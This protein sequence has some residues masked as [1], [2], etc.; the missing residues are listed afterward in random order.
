M[1]PILNREEIADLLAAVKAGRIAVETPAKGRPARPSLARPTRAIDLVHTFEQGHENGESRLPNFDIVLDTFARNVGI[2]LTNTLQRTFTVAREEI[3]ASTFQQS[4]ENL[5]HQGA[6]GIYTMA[7]LKSGCLFHFD[8]RLAFSL[9]ELMLG[10]ARS[11]DSP[12]LERHLTTIEMSILKT[13]MTMLC[14]ELER[15]MR[16]VVELQI[17]L[18]RVEN[19]F[20]M[21]NIVEPRAEVLVCRFGLRLGGEDAGQMRCIVPYLSFEP[22]REKFRGLVHVGQTAA[23]GWARLFAREVVAMECEVAARSGLIPMTIRRL[24]ALR[25]GE[26]VELPYNPDQP[27]TILVEGQPLF[28]A[29]AGERNGRG[30][31]HVTGRHC[32]PRGTIHG[33]T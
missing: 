2:S 30:A 21:V 1:E 23:R 8:T 33:D 3:L 7:P 24:L 18:T 27:L 17:G 15:A 29:I 31:V 22:L 11:G 6:V 19:N 5:E 26:V 13:T 28:T 12:A 9:L 4:L 25:S 14:S 32:N 10:A 16:P 20:R